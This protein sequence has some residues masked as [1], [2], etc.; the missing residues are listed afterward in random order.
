[1]KMYASAVKPDGK[2][3]YWKHS[4]LSP[5]E[6]CHILTRLTLFARDRTV[7]WNRS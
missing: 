4:T 7:W 1:M 6:L 3:V 2:D 5:P